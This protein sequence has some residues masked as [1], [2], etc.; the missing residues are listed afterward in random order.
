MK[1]DGGGSYS[2]F[3][4]APKLLLC[5]GQFMRIILAP[6]SFK[7]CMRAEAV[8]E[9]MRRG[10][11][12]VIPDAEVLSVP[13]AD[14]GE[15]TVSAAVVGAGGVTKK[16][17]VTGP[18]G[19][20]V[21]AVYA[22]LP[23]GAAV[24]ETASAAGL[25]LLRADELNPMRATT[26]GLGE[27]IL[28][29]IGSGAKEIIVGLGG[30]ATVDGGA[31]MA[32]ALGF[33]LLDSAGNAIK[34]GGVGL[35]D[36]ASVSAK[37]ADKRLKNV[38][39]HAAS[40]VKNPL[41]GANGA[42]RIFGPQKGAAQAMVDKLEEGMRHYA[43]VVTA[44][45]FAKNSDSPGDGAAGGLGFAMRAFCG[46]D[47]SSGAALIMRLADFERKISGADFVITGEG[48]TDSQTTSGK[49]CSVVAEVCAKH[50]VPVVLLSGALSGG[51]KDF[52]GP[53]AACLSIA[54][55]PCTLDEA[56]RDTEENLLI[57]A[58]SLAGIF[59]AAARKTAAP[60]RDTLL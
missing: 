6:D 18:L 7:G 42:A 32:Q 57:S 48:R 13:M 40:D 8:C 35:R 33:S 16:V 47:I 11:L 59:K 51:A 30:S 28:A 56:L 38:K 36:I 34:R 10:I 58:K 50:S 2:V 19:K 25:E 3:V 49:L 39:F 45:G 52:P 23:G 37:G 9:V 44:A 53:F 15:G 41:L 43:S 22:V 5:G 27:L 12:S 55:G 46:A 4:F 1:A 29:A 54:K 26:Y 24:V 60:A 31:G 17:T 21:E 14:G 20:P